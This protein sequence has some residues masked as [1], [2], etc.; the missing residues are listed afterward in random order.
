MFKG[1][2]GVDAP[3]AHCPFQ[4]RITGGGSQFEAAGSGLEAGGSRLYVGGSVPEAGGLRP[5][6]PLALTTGL[7]T[8][9]V[10]IDGM[11]RCPQ[12]L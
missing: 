9:N 3:V 12:E 11:S 7:A 1:L 8:L 2:R 5:R 6:D 10:S 4:Q